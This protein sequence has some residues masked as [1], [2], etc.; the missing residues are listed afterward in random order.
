MLPS[1][2]LRTSLFMG[3]ACEVV[4]GS[5]ATVALQDPCNGFHDFISG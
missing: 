3:S 5:I 1:G 4:V 2:R